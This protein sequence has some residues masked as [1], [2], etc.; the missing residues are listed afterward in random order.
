MQCTNSFDSHAELRRWHLAQFEVLTGENE[1]LKERCKEM[2]DAIRPLMQALVPDEP[3]PTDPLNAPEA[4]VD[5]CRRA[6]PLFKESVQDA[7]QHVASSVFAIARSHY[8]RIDL[9]RIE[10]GVATNTTEAEAEELR[11]N[12]WEIATRVM[13]DIRLVDEGSA[14]SAR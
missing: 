2:A 13:Q 8:P 11:N 7:G 4:A 10:E 6:W 5:Q 1:T 14:S 9:K 12:S 3:Q